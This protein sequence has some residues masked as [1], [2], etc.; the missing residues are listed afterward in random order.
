MPRERK[1]TGAAGACPRAGT[2]GAR[3]RGGGAYLCRHLMTV[4]VFLMMP[5]QIAHLVSTRTASLAKRTVSPSTPSAGAGPPAS[6]PSS[7]IRAVPEV[8]SVAVRAGPG[9]HARR[10]ARRSPA[11]VRAHPSPRRGSA[12]PPA[13][14]R[15]RVGAPAADRRRA[16]VAG[17]GDEDDEVDEDAYVSRQPPPPR[18]ARMRRAA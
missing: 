8:D 1:R 16:P 13:Q 4:V 15:A 10:A 12:A 5:M 18:A 6:A 9:A 17:D 2:G 11:R 14:L 3:P 7:P